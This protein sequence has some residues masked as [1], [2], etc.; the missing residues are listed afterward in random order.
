MYKCFLDDLRMPT[1]IFPTTKNREW[2]IVRNYDEFVRAIKKHGLP[3]FISF[4]HDLADEHYRASMFNADKHYTKYYNDGTFKEKTGYHAAKWLVD[5]CMTTT[6]PSPSGM[7]TAPIR[8]GL[9]TSVPTYNPTKEA[10][11]EK[12]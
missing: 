3:F 11:Y 1:N 10:D 2:T 6:V 7:F 9:K 5:Y 4:D 12:D 8:A